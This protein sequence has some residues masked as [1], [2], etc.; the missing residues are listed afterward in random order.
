MTTTETRQIEKVLRLGHHAD[1]GDTFVRV[2]FHNGKLSITGVEGP[3]KNGDCKGGCGQIGGHLTIDEYAPGWDA[4][5]VAKLASVW[6]RWHLNDM[7]AGCEHQRADNWGDE[8]V[9]VVTYG[10]TSEAHNM[11]RCAQE[12]AADAAIEGRPADLSNSEKWLLGPD[13]F[14][15]IHSPPDADSPMSGLF[16]VKKRETKHAGHVSQ[17]EH[18]RGVLSKPCPVCGYKY[19]TQWLSEEVP[20]DVLD[21]LESLPEADK[22]PAWV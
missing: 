19:G 14:K 21:W 8:Q 10:I 20:A 9:E 16:E 6:D 2:K 15:N 11:R 3:K 18:P 17:D 12:E 13:W 4:E 5:S 22:K 1:V 7:R